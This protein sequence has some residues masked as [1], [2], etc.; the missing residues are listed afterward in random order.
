[1]PNKQRSIE[2]KDISKRD[3]EWKTPMVLQLQWESKLQVQ[4]Y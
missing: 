3:E 1:M 2:H 4:W